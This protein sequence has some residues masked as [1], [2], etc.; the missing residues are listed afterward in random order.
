MRSER[1][2]GLDTVDWVIGQPWFGE[3]MV[4]YGMSYLGFVQWAMADQLPPQVRAMIPAVAESALSLEFLREDG[5]SLE[6]P[7]GWGVLVAGQE[8]RWAIPRQLLGAPRVR[9]AMSTLPLGEVDVAA[10]G[11]R[12]DYI[13]NVLAHD[14]GAPPWA[15]LDDSHRVAG[16]AVPVSS[17]GGWYDICL[18]GQLRDHQPLQAAGRRD[19]LTVGPWTH[20][21]RGVGVTAV[22]EALGFGLA[23]ARGE[24]PAE[25]APV[26]LFVMGEE[27]WRDFPSWPPPGYATQ[28]FHLHPGG[29]LSTDTAGESEP[30]GYRYDPA[31]PT[32]AVGGVRLA[33]GVK[34]GRVDNTGHEARPDVLTYTT[35]VLDTDVEVIGEGRRRDLV[36]L[37]PGPRGCVRPAVRRGRQGPLDERVRRPGRSD[38]R[39]TD[40]PRDGTAVADG[41]PL[42]ARSPHPGPGVQRCL[43]ALQPQS[44]HGRTQGDGHDSPCRE[45]GGVPRPGTSVRSTPAGRPGDTEK[46]LG[47]AR[48]R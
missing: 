17:V 45:P 18:P 48:A 37:R 23:H 27:A 3:S 43:P 22:G 47:R 31:D 36:P 6:T 46:R 11:Q 21:A 19:R 2:D 10:M 5:F 38:R 16:V 33:L 4:L 26:R 29:A 14:A 28:R 1:E 8:R 7:F 25:L 30:D 32:L 12:S 24:Q 41:P 39:R 44:G 35:P 20:T 40:L 13:Q 42:P 34:G 15:E 9:H